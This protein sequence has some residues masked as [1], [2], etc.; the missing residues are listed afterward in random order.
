MIPV[1]A[2]AELL[3]HVSSYHAVRQQE[4][5]VENE[6]AETTVAIRLMEAGFQIGRLK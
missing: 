2:R 3:K 5:S 1:V 6:F 4:E